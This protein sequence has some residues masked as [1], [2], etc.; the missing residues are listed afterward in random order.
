MPKPKV[1]VVD[2]VRLTAELALAMLAHGGVEA[3]AV[4]S[5]ER[6]LAWLDANEA[7]LI[8][9]DWYMPEMNGAQFAEAVVKRRGPK[10]PWMVAYT[11]YNDAEERNKIL[12]AGFDDVL[13]KPARA[14]VLASAVKLWLE[15]PR[16]D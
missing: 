12:A 7:A 5:G 11:A 4:N 8:L 2:D 16:A 9:S 6:A 13:K 3:E 14:D 1:L 15:R 10:R